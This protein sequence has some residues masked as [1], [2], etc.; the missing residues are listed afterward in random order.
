[1]A[2]PYPSF[3]IFNYDAFFLRLCCSGKADKVCGSVSACQ[4]ICSCSSVFVVCVW[5]C[6]F[7][8]CDQSFRCPGGKALD[9]IAHLGQ[10]MY[11]HYSSTA[12]QF[13]V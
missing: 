6:V 11:S 1:M 13:M 7:G 12:V 2:A 3:C 5:P 8:L 9:S 4:C 10:T